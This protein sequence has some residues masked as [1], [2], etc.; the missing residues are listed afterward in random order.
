MTASTKAATS[1][2][3]AAIDVLARQYADA[4][5]DLD[6]LT[7]ELKTEIDAAVRK[8]WADLRR[9][10]TRA[11]ERYDA[12]LAAVA[13]AREAFERPKTRIL[14]GVR[15]GYRKAADVVQVLNAD[16]TCALIKRLLPDQQDVL[17]STTETPVMD[18]LKQL[19]DAQLKLIGCRRVPGNDAPF[20][21]LA[22]TELDKVVAALMKSAI[23]K[24]EAEA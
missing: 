19:D 17:I 3:I 23:E 1:P 20:A 5:T 18:G 4:Q 21:K 6:T 9:A 14:H 24:A 13:D 22:D 8:R 12:L 15:V 10:T 11:A 7:N 2:E 16:N